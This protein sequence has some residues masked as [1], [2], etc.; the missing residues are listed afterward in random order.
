MFF[1]HVKR[2]ISK[3]YQTTNAGLV[4]KKKILPKRFSK[5]F[6]TKSPC[7]S[8]NERIEHH[9][10][11][12]YDR[13]AMKFFQSYVKLCFLNNAVHW[14]TSSKKLWTIILWFDI[15][16]WS[17]WSVI[18]WSLLQNMSRPEA[19]WRAIATISPTLWLKGNLN[20]NLSSSLA[21]ITVGQRLQVEMFLSFYPGNRRFSLEIT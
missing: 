16:F 21:S 7:I 6:F 2:T 15:C 5:Y 10:V 14:T 1:R 20:W 13:W 12:I 4:V 18:N 9:E 17:G 8:R 11:G 3:Q 19:Q